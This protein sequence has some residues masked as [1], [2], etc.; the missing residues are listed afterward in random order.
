MA[1]PEPQPD[2]WDV[3]LQPSQ[4][5]ACQQIDG[6]ERGNAQRKASSLSVEL[7]YRGRWCGLSWQPFQCFAMHMIAVLVP[8]ALI[9][10]PGFC[11][12]CNFGAGAA[13]GSLQEGSSC[14]PFCGLQPKPEFNLKACMTP[15]ALQ[16]LRP[17][18]WWLGWPHR[19]RQSFSNVARP[20]AS[21]RPPRELQ[22]YQLLPS[23]GPPT[24]GL[25][26]QEKIRLCR[27]MKR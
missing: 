25:G 14:A 22:R 23:S 7:R 26:S 13:L 17:P 9:A 20:L 8:A 10:C 12:G 5:V 6:L 1:L 24:G 2:A 11:S 27:S 3:A 4:Q 18:L 15:G 16:E 21:I 19:L